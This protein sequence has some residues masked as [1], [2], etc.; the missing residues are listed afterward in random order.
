MNQSDPLS[1]LMQDLN[2]V[3]TTTTDN[4]DDDE[5]QLLTF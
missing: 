4:Y 5:E 3:T 1:D 2:L